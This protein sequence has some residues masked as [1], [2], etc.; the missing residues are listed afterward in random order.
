MDYRERVIG[1]LLKIANNNQNIVTKDNIEGKIHKKLISP[2]EIW[3]N[4]L[5]KT[6][7]YDEYNKEI[8]DNILKNINN[9]ANIVNSRETMFNCVRHVRTYPNIIYC[10]EEINKCI[11]NDIFNFINLY[12][13]KNENSEI[14]NPRLTTNEVFAYLT[15]YVKHNGFSPDYMIIDS[16]SY[17][18]IKHSDYH[19]YIG[20]KSAIESTCGMKLFTLSSCDKFS[21]L[22]K[23]PMDAN[24]INGIGITIPEIKI[25]T[26]HVY[27]GMRS[28]LY[29][30]NSRR[31]WKIYNIIQL[32]GNI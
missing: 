11:L 21:I 26:T 1:E 25:I 15:E 13:Y 5:Y 14:I 23:T 6:P 16:F 28:I 27:S 22:G 3:T 9:F 31:T 30:W 4:Y 8:I 19:Y 24:T 20:G 10:K 32:K 29:N 17:N 18:V 12:C 2:R 7:C